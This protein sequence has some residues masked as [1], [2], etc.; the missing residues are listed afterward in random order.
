MKNTTWMFGVLV[1]AVF[2]GSVLY[3][4]KHPPAHP[5]VKCGE[6]QLNG[7]NGANCSNE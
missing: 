2:V 5:Q 3:I 4:Q 7:V 1:A 6:D